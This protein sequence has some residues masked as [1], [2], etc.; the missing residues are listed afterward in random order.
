MK[1]TLLLFLVCFSF[2]IKA[3]DNFEITTLRIGPINLKMKVEEAEK[4]AGKKLKVDNDNYENTNQVNY[5]GETISIYM[6][7]SSEAGKTHRNIGN[8][9]TKSPKFK[10]K[11]GM[12]VGS[13]KKQLI[14]AYKDYPDFSLS[15]SWDDDGKVSKT[16]SFFSLT[17]N[18]ASTI[19]SFEMK[20]DVVI[21]VA[22]Y[23]NDGGC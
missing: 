8:I 1:K 19:L 18:D 7:E 17:D 21:Q 22:V 4:I 23:Y 3:Q 14:E 10:T 12:G 6:Y 11:R 9:S 13:T 2:L 20:N 5:K 16:D 15:K